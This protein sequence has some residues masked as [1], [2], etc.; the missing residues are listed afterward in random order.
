MGKC[1]AQLWKVVYVFDIACFSKEK[2][3]FQEMIQTYIFQI[4]NL[5]Q[6]KTLNQYA[7]IYIYIYMYI[8]IHIY[9]NIAN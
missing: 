8:F 3:F 5:S 2:W 7:S 9:P 4:C 1:A 6:P